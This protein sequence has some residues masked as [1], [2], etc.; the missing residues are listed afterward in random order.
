MIGRISGGVGRCL[1]APLTQ[2]YRH[3]YLMSQ[4]CDLDR[5][6]LYV[7]CCT[8]LFVVKLLLRLFLDALELAVA[9]LVH[10]VSAE[11]LPNKRGTAFTQ[12]ESAKPGKM[13]GLGGR[14]A[15]MR[16]EVAVAAGPG[17]VHMR[18]RERISS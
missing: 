13:P 9:H 14:P 7:A 8:V 2:S 1:A 10:S 16:M 18:A 15:R 11:R 4:P 3:D 17:R 12:E 6:G 5:H